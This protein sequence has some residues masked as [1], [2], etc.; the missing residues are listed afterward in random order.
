METIQHPPIIILNSVLSC[1]RQDVI[2]ITQTGIIPGT[3]SLSSSQKEYT[4]SPSVIP[5]LLYLFHFC[6]MY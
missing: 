1:L 5:R 2:K 6:F 4:K 3:V